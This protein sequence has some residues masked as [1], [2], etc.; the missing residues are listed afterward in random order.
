MTKLRVLAEPGEALPQAGERDRLPVLPGDCLPPTTTL[1]WFWPPKPK[2]M[3]WRTY[4][5]ICDR[6][7]VEE[8]RL[9][10]ELWR[11]LV[12]LERCASEI[13]RSCG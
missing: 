8:G 3:R 11:V 6:L 7:E 12:R 13:P 4:T 5:A 10:A 2:G 1:H 9:D